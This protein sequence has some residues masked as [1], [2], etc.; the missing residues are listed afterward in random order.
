[1]LKVVITT[2]DTVGVLLLHA[3]S[4]GANVTRVE[5]SKLRIFAPFAETRR[6]V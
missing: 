3:V 5:A 2:D 6:D 1:M 4:S